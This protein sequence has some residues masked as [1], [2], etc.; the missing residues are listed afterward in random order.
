VELPRDLSW[1]RVGSRRASGASGARMPIR[2]CVI[3]QA[4]GAKPVRQLRGPVLITPWTVR[5]VANVDT[6]QTS[7]V[8]SR[9]DG[10]HHQVK[11]PPPRHLCASSLR[12]RPPSGPFET[13]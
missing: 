9:I 11:R 3:A 2:L 4:R 10:R 1:A 13:A 12:R 5:L 6:L 8:R 7:D